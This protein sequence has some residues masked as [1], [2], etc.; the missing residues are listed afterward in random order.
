[1][2]GFIGLVPVLGSPNDSAFGNKEGDDPPGYMGRDL[3]R[4]RATDFIA[5]RT[6][7]CTI[8]SPASNEKT[9]KLAS[10]N[11][12]GTGGVLSNIDR[13]RREQ[14]VWDLCV[15]RNRPRL[16]STKFACEKICCE[17]RRYSLSQN[18]V[19]APGKKGV[20]ALDKIHDSRK[21]WASVIGS[22]VERAFRTRHPRDAREVI[23]FSQMIAGLGCT[24]IPFVG[25][26]LKNEKNLVDGD[27]S[28]D[29]FAK[30]G[31]PSRDD[32][33]EVP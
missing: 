14:V 21:L 27:T 30:G 5:P 9:R 15:E 20:H 32:D 18:R 2:H 19:R 31:N 12:A 1:M 33:P 26:S 4:C 10:H 22:C 25:R 7:L 8:R 17:V 28:F 13:R 16:H 3:D 6:E 24:H 11:F 29:E 23:G